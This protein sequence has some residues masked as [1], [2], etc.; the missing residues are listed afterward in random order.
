MMHAYAHA[1]QGNYGAKHLRCYSADGGTPRPRLRERD[2][3]RGRATITESSA[4]C[5]ATASWGHVG[6]APPGTWHP[7]AD[8]P[9]GEQIRRWRRRSTAVAGREGT[10]TAVASMCRFTAAGRACACACRRCSS[11]P[12]VESTKRPPPGFAHRIHRGDEGERG[13]Q[14]GHGLARCRGL[15]NSR[16]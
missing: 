1:M 3:E 14:R 15:P 7:R 4:R 13:S 8:P 2:S 16:T 5:R 11:S 12:P 9:L 10:P 6:P